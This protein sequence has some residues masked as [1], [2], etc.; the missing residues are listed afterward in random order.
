MGLQVLLPLSG[1]LIVGIGDTA[2]SMY[3]IPDPCLSSV[4]ARELRACMAKSFS[5]ASLT[6]SSSFV[7]SVPVRRLTKSTQMWL[8]LRTHTL[9]EAR[10]LHQPKRTSC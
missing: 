9:A 8:T 7:E 2:A 1:V 5:V 4:H 10:A 3:G 6:V